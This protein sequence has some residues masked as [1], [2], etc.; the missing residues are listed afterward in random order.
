[1][2]IVVVTTCVLNIVVSS[3]FEFFLCN[4]LVWLLFFVVVGIVGVCCFG[5]YLVQY[6]VRS[7]FVRCVVEL[8]DVLL[9]LLL[10][11][12]AVALICCCAS[13]LL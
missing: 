2:F 8:Q 11:D 10:N 6:L 1:M 7:W 9:P 5:F 3:M 4:L 13:V 12:A